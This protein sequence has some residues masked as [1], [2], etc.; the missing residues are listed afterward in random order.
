MNSLYV[1]CYSGISGDMIVAALLDLGASKQVLLKGLESLKVDGYKIEISRVNQNG[2]N[3]CDFNV[4][5]N[6]DIVNSTNTLIESERNIFDIFKIIES[7]LITDNAKK[8]SKKI[9]EIKASA[10]ASAH[11][12]S[13]EEVYFHEKGA[14][15][16][17][18]DIVSA[19]ICLDNLEINEVIVSQI[20]DGSGYL[21]CR[22]GII[23]VPVP[24]VVNIV[25]E[26]NLDLK[27]TEING[28]MVTPTGAAIIAAIRT[29]DIL[30][31]ELSCKKTG[32]GAGKRS[33]PNEGILRMYLF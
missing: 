18:I 5:L 10:E 16:S 2:I 1:E 22:R 15:D 20:N 29:S 24:A 27:V 21:K 11:E 4:V 9:F 6:D 28:E 30:P 7:S 12:T 13:I 19:A 31:K 33:Y 23:P 32:L 8:L 3:A 14:V 26:Y 17:I 25:E